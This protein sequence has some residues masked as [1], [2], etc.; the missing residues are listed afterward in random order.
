MEM[1]MP[2]HTHTGGGGATPMTVSM[3]FTPFQSSTL[4]LESL[5]L[6][7]HNVTGTRSQSGLAAV[8]YFPVP[9][10]QRYRKG[11]FVDTNNKHRSDQLLFATV[12]Q[13]VSN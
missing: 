7:E 6:L 10:T 4:F 12:L 11:T 13:R 5:D 8:S 3:P 1:C 2:K 9:S